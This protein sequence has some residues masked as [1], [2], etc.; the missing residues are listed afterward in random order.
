MRGRR[1]RSF[2]AWL[3]LP[4]A[5]ASVACYHLAAPYLSS[6]SPV[7]RGVLAFLLVGFFHVVTCHA[8]SRWPTVFLQDILTELAAYAVVGTVCGLLTGV[9]EARWGVSASPLWPALAVFVALALFF[10]RRGS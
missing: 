4:V 8:A 3:V 10:D 2:P 6:T 7:V 5:A 9:L 1:T